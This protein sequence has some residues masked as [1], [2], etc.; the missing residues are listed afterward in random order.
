MATTSSP[1]ARTNPWSAGESDWRSF[2]AV[3]GFVLVA[4]A[5]SVAIVFVVDLLYRV[6]D[7]RVRL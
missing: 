3:Q 5:R 1:A 4:G 2:P 7:P 6:I